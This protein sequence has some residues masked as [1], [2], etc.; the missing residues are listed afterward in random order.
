MRPS[1]QNVPRGMQ[2]LS[3]QT[4]SF[5]DQ[6]MVKDGTATKISQQGLSIRSQNTTIHQPMYE[7]YVT[8]TYLSQ[9]SRGSLHPNLSVSVTK[10]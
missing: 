9:Y 10:Y 6:I 4:A 1:N 2:I 5:Q 7:I 8:V 3:R